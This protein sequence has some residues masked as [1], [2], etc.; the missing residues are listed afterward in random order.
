MY[1]KFIVKNKFYTS[2]SLNDDSVKKIE[3]FSEGL[4][5]IMK[6]TN[7]LEIKEEIFVAAFMLK[8]LVSH[9]FW[10]ILSLNFIRLLLASK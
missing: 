7:V 10:H 8:R 9:A 1:E 5:Y 2:F 6:N 3:M 4:E